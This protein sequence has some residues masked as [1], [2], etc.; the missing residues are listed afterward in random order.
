M[1]TEQHTAT[2]D[3]ITLALST[4]LTATLKLADSVSCNNTQV[5]F[6]LADITKGVNRI[7]NLTQQNRANLWVTLQNKPLLEK[8][9]GELA[10]MTSIIAQHYQLDIEKTTRL[11]ITDFNAAA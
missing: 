1:N 8:A 11:A 10:A 9:L 7:Q 3:H 2:H 4:A 5:F 6:V